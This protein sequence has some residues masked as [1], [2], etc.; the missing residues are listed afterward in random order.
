MFEIQIKDLK[1]LLKRIHDWDHMD[2]ASDG[3][4]WRKE[5]QKI[6]GTKP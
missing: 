3:P 1:D 5:I 2:Y 6:L 4:Y